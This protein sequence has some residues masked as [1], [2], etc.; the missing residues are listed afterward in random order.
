MRF[1][2]HIIEPTEL[3]LAW[4]SSDEKHR[5][6]YIVAALNRVD[7]DISL[8][9]LVDTPDFHT[10]LDRGFDFYPAFK[11]HD[12]IHS[13]VLDAF[14]RRLPPR[15]RGD[16]SEYLAGI[17]LKPDVELS[18]FALLG[19]SGAKLLSDGFSIIHPFRHVEGPCELLIEA[20]GFRHRKKSD[21]IEAKIDASV[22]FVKEECNSFTQESA[23]CIYA[24]N[25]NIGYVNRALIPTFLDWIG[26][27]R[28]VNAWVEKVNGTPERP[29]AYIYVEVAAKQ[30]I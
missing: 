24:D 18:D 4:Q 28:I 27:G 16:F 19:Y 17:R 29:T 23:I 5:T 20:A 12:R 6:R 25:V 30:T 1:I 26:S 8:K 21:G 7:N 11:E 9:Y 14:M 3:L 2:Q 10:A 15:K 22:S 13:N